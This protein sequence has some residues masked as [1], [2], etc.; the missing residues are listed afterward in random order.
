MSD[1]RRWAGVVA[2]GALAGCAHTPDNSRRPL[3]DCARTLVQRGYL[4]EDETAKADEYCQTH[5]PEQIAD[6]RAAVDSKRAPTFHKA[7]ALRPSLMPVPA[8]VS[9]A[10]IAPS[11]PVVEAPPVV[12]VAPVVETPPVESA[13][14]R[15]VF[16]VASEDEDL[17]T[18]VR[19]LEQAGMSDVLRRPGHITLLAPTNAALAKMPNLANN[20]ARLKKVMAAHVVMSQVHSNDAPAAPAKP[21]RVTSLAGKWFPMRADEDGNVSIG[22]ARVLHGDVTATNGHIEVIDAVLLP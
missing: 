19:L 21:Q 16:A 15:D 9:V 1:I 10:A 14:P 22:R 3:S 5:S 18:F 20:K 2:F 8:P 7:L 11:E 17:S 12:A 13:G 4:E 6:A